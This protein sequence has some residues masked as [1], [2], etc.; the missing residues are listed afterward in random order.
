MLDLKTVFGLT[1][2]IGLM[3]MFPFHRPIQRFSTLAGFMILVITSMWDRFTPCLG[4]SKAI[5]FVC[6]S[7][8]PIRIT[9]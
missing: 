8:F 6:I 4:A 9:R 7:W 3:E 5:R 1:P 2:P